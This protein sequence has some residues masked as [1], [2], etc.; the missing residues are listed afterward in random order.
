MLVFPNAKINLG[1]EVLCRRS[2]G[3]HDIDTVMIP[4]PVR[5]ALEFVAS[6][7]G[8]DNYHYS[9]LSIPQ[10]AAANTIQKALELMRSDFEIPALDIYLHKAIPMGAGMGGGSADGAFMLLALNNHFG[11]HI[12]VPMLEGYASQIGSDCTFFIQNIPTRA[13]GRGEILEQLDLNLNGHHL[14]LVYLGLHISTGQAY[15]K[16]M[17]EI[18]E[19]FPAQVVQTLPLAEWRKYLRNRFESYAF[20]TFPAIKNLRDSMYA[21]GALYAAMTGSGSAVY[22]IFTDSDAARAAAIAAGFRFREMPL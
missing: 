20:E 5:D 17:P 2:D 1:L 12:D 10:G 4:V 6:A 21:Q 15:A 11:L 13:T 3:Y 9:G 8:V 14:L 22:G 7:N 16:I 18:P 19:F